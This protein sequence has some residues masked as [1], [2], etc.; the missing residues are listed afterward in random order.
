MNPVLEARSLTYSYLGDR[1][2][3]NDLDLV[4]EPG[5]RFALA[6]DNGSGKSTLLLHLNGTLRPTAGAVHRN[7]FPAGY[8]REQLLAWR[9]QVG[10]VL[11][12]S[13][14]QLFAPTV[15]EDVSFGPMNLELP[16]AEVRERVHSALEQLAI[17]DLAGSEPSQLSHGQ[18]KRVAIAGVLAMRPEVLLLDEP[19]AGLDASS[20]ELLLET[21]S[22]LDATVLL[23]T[24]DLKR[25]NGWATRQ[26]VMERGRVAEEPA[27]AVVTKRAKLAQVSICMGCCC[28]RTDKG[29]PEVPVDWLKAE[30]KQKKLLKRVQLSISGCL[31]P[32]DVANVIRVSSAAG[33]QWIARV[34]TRE[35]FEQLVLWAEDVN[36]EDR[37][38]PLPESF[39]ARR[40]EVFR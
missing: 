23:T 16:E 4:L 15:Y 13:D 12:N 31:G 39:R 10:L 7:G 28:G 37:L 40:F 29:Y 6:G 25:T 30:W 11:Q 27:S 1:L 9:H 32:C 20:T 14:D 33:E 24:H 8:R 3:L 34:N 5:D 19:T 35:E 18:K 2:V 26:G 17:A 21:L 36:H 38:L 22:T